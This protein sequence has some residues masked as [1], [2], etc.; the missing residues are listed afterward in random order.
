MVDDRDPVLMRLFAEQRPPA[1]G[2]EFAS[3]IDAL[4]QRDLRRARI[5]RIGMI[6]GAAIVASLL[7]PWIAQACALAIGSVVVGLGTTRALL[8]SPLAWLAV[9][10]ILA[11]F[12]PVIYLGI[13][14]RW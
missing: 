3:R 12:L 1:G 4:M 13:T 11:A 6:A 2:S 14:R 5:H 8:G 7:A 10:S 9:F